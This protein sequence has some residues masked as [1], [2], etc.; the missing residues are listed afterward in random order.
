[1]DAAKQTGIDQCKTNPA[2]CGIIV[3]STGDYIA[4]K[5]D[6]I[7][8]CKTNPAAYGIIV[9]DGSGC[10]AD[11]THAVYNPQ[12]GEVY[13]PFIDAPGALGI[14][15]QVYEVYLL[16]RANSFM[17]DLDLTRVKPR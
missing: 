10:G 5:Q 3:P 14:G 17:F 12:T 15:T 7:A 9:T 1:M 8:Q 13:I 2:S 11:A 4:G 16:Q 6:G